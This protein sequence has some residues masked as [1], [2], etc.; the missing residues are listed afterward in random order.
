LE[1][2]HLEPEG[3]HVDGIEPGRFLERR[4]LL[5]PDGSPETPR[6]AVTRQL[7]FVTEDQTAAFIVNAREGASGDAKE[8]ANLSRYSRVL[9]PRAEGAHLPPPGDRERTERL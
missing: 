3:G 9:L 2:R 6:R 5:A 1:A 4:L 8:L 7:A